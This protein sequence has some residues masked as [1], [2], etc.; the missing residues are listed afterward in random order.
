MDPDLLLMDESFSSLDALTRE[1]LERLTLELQAETGLTT[2]IVTHSIEEAVYLGRRLLLLRQPPHHTPLVI[3][4]P[5]AGN[6]EYRTKP[7]LQMRC[8]QVRELL[9]GARE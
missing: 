2:I 8:N 1:D 4:N 7:E 6:S 5:D 9:E 3:E